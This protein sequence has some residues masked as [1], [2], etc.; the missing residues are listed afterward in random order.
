M[1]IGF[2]RQSPMLNG[3]AHWLERD[4]GRKRGKVTGMGV[5]FEI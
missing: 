5:I 2:D 4:P 3:K 1:L